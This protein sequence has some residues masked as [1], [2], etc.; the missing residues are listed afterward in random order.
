MRFAVFLCYSVRCLYVILCGFAVLIPP[1]SLLS[2]D[3]AIPCTSHTLSSSR[4]LL[5]YSLGLAVQVFSKSSQIRW[6]R[7]VFFK[8]FLITSGSTTGRWYSTSM[9]GLLGNLQDGGLKA[10]FQ[11][12]ARPCQTSP[13]SGSWVLSN[14]LLFPSHGR[15]DWVK[16][17]RYARPP[18]PRA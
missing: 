4:H 9:Q 2:P 6:Y 17:P 18:S 3:D 12:L 10:R 14:F 1:Y 11:A 8:G 13:P 16:F 5:F 7:R 15:G